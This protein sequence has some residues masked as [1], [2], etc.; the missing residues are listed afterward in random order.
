MPSSFWRPLSKGKPFSH[1]LC[2]HFLATFDTKFT[3]LLELLDTGK[4]RHQIAL[5][6]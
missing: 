4:S 6:V 3:R 1:V 5:V 2:V